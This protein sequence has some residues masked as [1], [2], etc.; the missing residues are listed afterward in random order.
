MYNALTV[1][2]DG[3]IIAGDA[4]IYNEV[5]KDARCCINQLHLSIMNDEYECDTFVHFDPSEWTVI[6]RTKHDRFIHYVL[7]PV[8]SGVNTILH[9]LRD[10]YLN[11]TIREGRNGKTKSMFGKTKKF[12]LTDGFPLLTTKK[13]FF[14]GVV[15]LLIFIR[16][17]T[18]SKLL[19]D[20][21]N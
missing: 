4:Q 3:K 18:D 14:R 7:C 6:E 17:D 20:K 15:E 9:L 21:K 10:V 16:G 1:Y 11:G 2:N 12:V 8:E 13:M 19:D 5:F